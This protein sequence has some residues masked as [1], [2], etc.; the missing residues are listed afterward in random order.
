M[1]TS[2]PVRRL[3]WQR[4]RQRAELA[5]RGAHGL[6]RQQTS[7]ASRT[8]P[9]THCSH[10]GKWSTSSA[11]QGSGWE[12]RKASRQSKRPQVLRLC[13][14]VCAARRLRVVEVWQCGSHVSTFLRP[15]CSGD[16]HHARPPRRLDVLMAAGCLGSRAGQP[17]GRPTAPRRSTPQHG[18]VR[19]SGGAGRCC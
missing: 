2:A 1:H 17:G 12:L 7:G 10:V 9:R 5:C 19:E 8:R 14:C 15:R 18:A 4:I 13:V 3:Q 16:M 6:A 11:G